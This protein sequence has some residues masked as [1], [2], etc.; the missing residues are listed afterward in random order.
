VFLLGATRLWVAERRDRPGQNPA[1]TVQNAVSDP[2]K[3]R[4]F[5]QPRSGRDAERRL[6]DGFQILVSA[7]LTAA[8]VWSLA[9]WHK[10]NGQIPLDP[11]Q[12]PA[13]WVLLVGGTAGFAIRLGV[14]IARWLS[15]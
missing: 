14:Q 3:R 5:A 12:R 10:F 8:L 1:D 6:W 9:I 4:D 7:G 13:G 2:A 11:W 15:R